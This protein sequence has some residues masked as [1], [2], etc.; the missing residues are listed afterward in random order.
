MADRQEDFELIRQIHNVLI[1]HLVEG[2]K[3]SE[4]AKE[5]NLTTS[6]VNRLI[7]RG[8]KLGMVKVDIESPFKTLMD[9]ERDLAS[10]TGLT[11]AVVTPSVSG[12]LDTTLYQVGRA[13]S[14][15]LVKT[16]RDGDVIA[17]TGGKAV[18]AV[19][20]S[21]TPERSL[22]VTVVPL[23]GGVQGK[24]Y[25]DVNH[26][27]MRMAERLGGR[28]I[29]LHAPLFAENREKRDM[30]MGIASIREALDLAGKANLALV[31]IGS[32]E[33]EDSS[34][35]DLYPVPEFDRRM[36]IHQGVVSELL[37]HLINYNGAVSN[38]ALNSRLVTLPLAD[39]TQCGRVIGIAAGP[40]K[41]LLIKAV[42]KGKF[43]NSLIVDED[44]AR[45]V[46]QQM[47]GNQNAKRHADTRYRIHWDQGIGHWSGHLGHR[48]LDV[49][50]YG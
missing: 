50:R 30:L 47:E 32:V 38:F 17:I 49:G 27:A 31:G 29:L 46:L 39:L 11:D 34:Y 48:W 21:L 4:I 24:Y 5:L 12:S 45:A 7:M 9:L 18:S 2:R 20:E 8:R 1:L 10:A 43:L 22:D 26:L 14:S 19:V 44:T 15:H 23:T 28:A 16:L 36:L 3:Q 37:A 42:L 40:Q 33:A 35:Y 25:T 41:V 6:K 13:A